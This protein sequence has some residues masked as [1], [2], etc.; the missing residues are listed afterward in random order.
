[1]VRDEHEKE[2]SKDQFDKLWQVTKE[3]RLEK[4]RYLISF[5]RHIIEL[6]VFEGRLE[7]LVMVGVEFNSESEANNF[8]IPGW[9]G[10]EVT[11]ENRFNN[12]VLATKRQ[13][14]NLILNK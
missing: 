10:R 12:F 13:F 6:D 4:I 7:G 11:N 5:K 9:F 2:I 1:M 8:N 3:N 14:D